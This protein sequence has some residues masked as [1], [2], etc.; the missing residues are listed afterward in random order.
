MRPVITTFYDEKYQGLYL[1]F[2]PYSGKTAEKEL[3][4]QRKLH[5]MEQGESLKLGSSQTAKENSYW[6]QQ[7]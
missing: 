4:R 3:K 1:T 7:C 2:K 5:F 6:R